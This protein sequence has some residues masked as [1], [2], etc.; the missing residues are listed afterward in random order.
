MG[1]AVSAVASV[2]TAVQLRCSPHHARLQ[3]C[4]WYPYVFRNSLGIPRTVGGVHA[5]RLV[6]RL[7][8]MLVFGIGVLF[9]IFACVVAFQD[10]VW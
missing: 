10:V 4:H 1:V 7:C 8:G 6:A 2:R 5:Q 9:T 3:R